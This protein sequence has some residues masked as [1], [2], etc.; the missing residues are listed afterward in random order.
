MLLKQHVIAASERVHNPLLYGTEKRIR[1]ILFSAANRTPIINI[2]P[3]CTIV[4]FI[5]PFHFNFLAFT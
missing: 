4:P 2:S 5:F 1:A 3:G